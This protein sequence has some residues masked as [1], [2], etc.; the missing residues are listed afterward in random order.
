MMSFKKII[1]KDKLNIVLFYINNKN[2]IKKLKKQIICE[3]NIIFE[4]KK[5]PIRKIFEKI[6]TLL[7]GIT[8]FI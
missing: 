8:K 6:N 7:S 4:R 2:S 3:K 5:S 1:S